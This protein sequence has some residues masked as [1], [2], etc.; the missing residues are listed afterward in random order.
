MYNVFCFIYLC[1]YIRSYLRYEIP[2]NF[3][4]TQ[5]LLKLARDLL[6][7]IL[8]RDSLGRYLGYGLSKTYIRGTT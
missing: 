3:G 4:S 5:N 2:W 1:V 8:N 7:D 6:R